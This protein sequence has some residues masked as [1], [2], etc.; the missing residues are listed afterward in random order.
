MFFLRYDLWVREGL[1][2]RLPF[3]PVWRLTA[4]FRS[5][6]P[7]AEPKPGVFLRPGAFSVFALA[8]QQQCPRQPTISA[9]SKRT[10]AVNAG[11]H[12][13]CFSSLDY[14]CSPPPRADCITPC[15]R[16]R[17]ELRLVHPEATI[18]S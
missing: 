10:G 11:T 9:T 2:N 7:S 14:W 17:F 4:H 16:S 12:C 5:R 3:L 15:G 6:T 18:R 13:C 1:L 8:R